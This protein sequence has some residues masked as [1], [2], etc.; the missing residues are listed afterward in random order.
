M[1]RKIFLVILAISLGII[2]SA[3]GV[4]PAIG[5]LNGKANA[6]YFEQLAPVNNYG[7]GSLVYLNLPTPSNATPPA[8]AGTPSHPTDLEI[9]SYT[10]YSYS[11][12]GAYN[13]MLVSL[14][15]PQLN[16]YEQVAFITTASDITLFENLW[17]KT[18]VWY[19]TGFAP[20]DIMNVIQVGN[21][22]LQIWASYSGG[23]M[24]S[25]HKYDTLTVNLTAPVAIN[26][27]FNM[28]TFYPPLKALGNL[29]FTLPPLTL[30][31]RDLNA[32]SYTD[33]STN[34][35]LPSGYYRQPIAEMRTPAWVEEIV[36]SWLG[37]ASPLEVSGHIDW[38]FTESITPPA[39]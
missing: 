8:P 1:N 2:I 17:N 7:I 10:F 25:G 9:R 19:K 36:P 34:A 18:F 38:K 15:V 33:L 16:A 6:C 28:W 4:F 35:T 32:G 5:T 37:E 24:I 3:A 23:H 14:W 22:N 26:L 39:S 12:A 20:A 31:F 30:T 27:P 13:G 11:Y 21:D 29:S